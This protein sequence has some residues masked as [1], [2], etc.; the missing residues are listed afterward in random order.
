[1]RLG[2]MWVTLFCG[3]CVLGAVVFVASL[4]PATP[5][6]DY[7][8]QV[9]NAQPSVVLAADGSELTTFRRTRQEWVPLARVSPHLLHAL[10]ATED[11]RFFRHHGADPGRTLSAAFRTAGGDT[12]GGSTITQQLARNLFPAEIGRARTIT[13][14][15]KEII[16]A[17]KIER[18]YSKAQ[19]LE[20]YLNTMPFLYNV[21]GIEMAARTY[22]GKSAADLDALESA[23]LVGMLKG[24]HY[25]NPVVNPER[26]RARRNIVLAQMRKHQHLTDAEFQAL[27]EQPLQVRFSNQAEPPG[28]SPHFTGHV[29]KWV[30]KWAEQHDHDLYADGLVIHTT[31][32]QP[33]QEAA[34]LAV[35]RQADALQNIADVEWGQRSGRLLSSTP[36]AYAKMR[37][38]IQPF[39]HFWNTRRDLVETFIKETPEYKKALAA[40][41]T[42]AAILAG[43]QKDAGF[44]A[45]LRAAKTRLEA[46]FVAIDPA[47]GEVKA[48]VGSRD[49]ERDHY[50]HVAQAERQPG[51]TFKPIVYG[52][53]LERGL[54]PDQAY[55]DDPVEIRFANNAVWRPTDMRSASGRMMTLR[56]GLIFSKNTITAQVMQDVGVPGIVNLAQA[57]GVNQSKLDPV[58]SLA[59]GTSPVTL[60]EMV[61]AYATIAQR[62]EYRQ[63][64]FIKRITDRAGKVLAEFG[65]DT[66]R[67]MSQQTAIELIDMMRGVVT[68][69][70]GQAMKSRFGIEADIAGK[71]GTTQNNADGW[72]IAM[73]PNLVAGSWVGFNDARVT[74]R[75]AYWGQGGHNALFVVGDFFRGALK[76]K[77]IDATA[78]F[79]RPARAPVMAAVEAKVVE[80]AE[81]LNETWYEEMTAPAIINH[82]DSADAM[83]DAASRRPELSIRGIERSSTKTPQELADI[84]LGMGRDPVTGERVGSGR[85]TDE[86]VPPRGDQPLPMEV[87]PTPLT[88]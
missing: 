83:I 28:S 33:L 5:A 2:L 73:H 66:R 51:S 43:L 74:M 15:L 58:P 59:L 42:E 55:R 21:H 82:G 41:G 81:D 20:T 61:S 40:G 24:T 72:F 62:G 23:M 48:W 64:V 46:S 34:L 16:T 37:G 22:Y 11:H 75:S 79:P 39:G 27:R 56:E 12:Q 17:L 88:E 26:A 10:I 7:L 78:Q 50:D 36:D 52:A 25:Y 6:V 31:L 86:L 1:M 4:V 14:K 76:G 85:R 35:A 71:T 60:L 69:G 54:S 47:T 3:A 29:R 9:Q 38:G 49:F 8:Q 13:R 53:A 80:P 84:L 32:D 87:V 18:A 67:G 70:T 77:L 45:R 68:R 30:T 57:M 44:I 19:I 65:G 63:P